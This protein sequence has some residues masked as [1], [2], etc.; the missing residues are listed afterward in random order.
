MS[1]DLMA[2]FV[3]IVLP[4][5]KAVV[6]TPLKDLDFQVD[7]FLSNTVKEMTG[8]GKEQLVPELEELIK[9]SD[10]KCWT[11]QYPVSSRFIDL[12]SRVQKIDGKEADV[13]EITFI[14]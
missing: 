8:D 5:T 1:F 9:S 7:M 6:L 11:R 3:R 12:I 4:K 2:F 14:E 10:I 13:F